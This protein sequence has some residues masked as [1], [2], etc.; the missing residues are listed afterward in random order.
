[1]I[2]NAGAGENEDRLEVAR[3]LYTTPAPTR[4]DNGED[5]I[6]HF[7]DEP[8]KGIEGNTVR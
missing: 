2:R 7:I 6:N 4:R 1:M 8:V 3:T 5:P